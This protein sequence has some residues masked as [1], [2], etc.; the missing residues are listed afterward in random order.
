MTRHQRLFLFQGK[1]KTKIPLTDRSVSAV[2]PG[3]PCPECGQEGYRVA[4]KNKRI[5][6]DDRAYESDAYCTSCERPVGTLRLEVSTIFGLREDNA[7]LRGR[8]RVY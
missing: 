4:G 1:K 5:A 3:G 8:C 7:V 6:E 2:A